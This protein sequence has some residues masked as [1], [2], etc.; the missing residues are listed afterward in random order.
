MKETWKITTDRLN[1]GSKST[2]INSLNVGNIEIVSKR[3]I[4]NTTNSYFCSVCEEL[5]NKI[6]DCANSLLTGMYAMNN[7]STKFHF[8]NIQDQHIR[9]AMAKIKTSKGFV[10]DN[11][12]SYFLNLAL[13]VISKSFICLFNRPI[14]QC[15]F[16]ASGKIP[17]VTPICKDGEKIVRENYRPIT[18]HFEAF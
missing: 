16:P 6:E 15:K 18:C 9:D 1:E 7:C 14:S 8:Y 10:T 12:S 3:A 2:K 13:P 4:S 5:A 17:R 11:L